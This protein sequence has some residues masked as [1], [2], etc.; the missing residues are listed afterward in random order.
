MASVTTLSLHRPLSLQ[1]LAAQAD[2]LE[3][4]GQIYAT[5][6]T[7]YLGVLPPAKNSPRE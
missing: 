3:S 2:S 1:E 6:S 5:G 7:K 4:F